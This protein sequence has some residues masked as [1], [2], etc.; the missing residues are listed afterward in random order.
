MRYYK[1]WFFSRRRNAYVNKKPFTTGAANLAQAIAKY[2][3][4]IEDK[5]R[6]GPWDLQDAIHYEQIKYIVKEIKK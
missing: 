3:M 1:V 2:Q 5:Y 6:I 4:Y